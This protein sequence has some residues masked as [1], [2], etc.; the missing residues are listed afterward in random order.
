[1]LEM[2]VHQSKDGK[3]VVIHDGSLLRTCGSDIKISD[4]VVGQSP[5][6]TLPQ[7]LRRIPIFYN[8][9]GRELL[10]RP[11]EADDGVPV[12][13]STRVC[14]LTEVFERLRGVPL[15][16]DIKEDSYAFVK[17]VLDLIETYHRETI[18]FVGSSNSRNKKHFKQYFKSC[19]KEKRDRYR[20]FGNEA[21]FWKTH[22]LYR[23]G[24]L[25]FVSLDYDV[26]SIPIHIGSMRK[27]CENDYGKYLPILVAGCLTSPLLWRYLQARGIAVVA[28]VF[29]DETDIREAANFPV[30]GLMTD[31]PIKLSKIIQSINHKLNI[32][33]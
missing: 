5:D 26:F 29:N 6:E 24:L 23:T 11:F 28:F 14:L 13:S 30:N 1:M 22:F 18:T 10:D 21:D 17:S 3:I 27:E 15:H 12:N 20:L 8:A 4:V 16:I 2:D 32:L 25:P 33:N 7:S 9:Y 31:Y 19:S